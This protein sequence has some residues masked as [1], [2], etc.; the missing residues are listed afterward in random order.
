M[1]RRDLASKR[2][3]L[4]L[5]GA[6]V[7]GAESIAKPPWQNPLPRHNLASRVRQNPARNRS[8]SPPAVT[9]APG[10]AAWTS[11]AFRAAKWMLDSE[12]GRDVV[13]PP[14]ALRRTGIRADVHPLTDRIVQST[15]RGKRTPKTPI[16]GTTED[17]A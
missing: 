4:F 2:M 14:R 8:I 3:Q 1:P 17:A 9:A 16:A 15:R 5:T 13:S 10:P 6:P 7:S 12:L 11:W